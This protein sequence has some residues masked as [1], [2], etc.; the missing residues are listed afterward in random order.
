MNLGGAYQPEELLMFRRLFDECLR[1]L[2]E[3]KCTAINQARIAKQLLDCAATGERN[4]IELR[5][6]A[7]PSPID[8][9]SNPP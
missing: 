6:P 3:N 2:P 7:E 5:I 4:P 1:G 9:T 8:G